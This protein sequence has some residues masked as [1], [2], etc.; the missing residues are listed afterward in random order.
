MNFYKNIDT[1]INNQNLIFKNKLNFSQIDEIKKIK[2]YKT[3]KINV[4]RNH[5]FELC[6]KLLNTF[7]NNL[8]INSKLNLSA[9]DDSFSLNN[10]K[11]SDLEI[12]WFDPFF[13]RKIYKKNKLKWIDK[14][15]IRLTNKTKNQIIFC[16]WFNTSFDKKLN[17]LL[18]KFNNIHYFNLRIEAKKKSSNY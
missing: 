9:Y 14:L 11:K 15:F 18:N 8:G 6:S 17:F 7:L 3:L 13:L 10:F 1:K 16:S 12:I 4:W 2:T 5:Q